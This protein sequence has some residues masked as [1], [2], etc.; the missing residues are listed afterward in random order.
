MFTRSSS[1]L[2]RALL[3]LSQSSSYLDSVQR[4]SVSSHRCEH[5]RVD[6]FTMP[7]KKRK[8]G[9]STKS[10]APEKKAR[11]GDVSII[12]DAEEPSLSSTGRPKRASVGE[13]RY[14]LTRRRSTSDPKTTPTSA[15][16]EK[17]TPKKRGRPAKVTST[18]PDP[19]SALSVVVP[20]KRGRPAKHAVAVTPKSNSGKTP[21]QF[22]KKTVNGKY[23]R[24]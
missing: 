4:Q 1:C 6:L 11:F 23:N 5:L 22:A 24:L 21:V 10:S 2:P 12:P 3:V 8:A 19:P 13:P 9:A 17:T 15:A 7:A 14:D 18:K 20:K 16:A